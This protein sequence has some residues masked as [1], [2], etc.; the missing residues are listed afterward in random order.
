M[1]RIARKRDPRRPDVTRRGLLRGLGAGAAGA[2]ALGTGALGVHADDGDDDEDDG[3]PPLRS[4]RF[5]RMYSLPP[6][7]PPSTSVRNALIEMGRPG[8]ILD[9]KD[10]LDRGPV[11]LIIDPALS[12]TN[13]N[14]PTQTAGVTFIGQFRDHDITFDAGSRLGIPT[15]PQQSRNARTPALDLDSVYGGGPTTDPHLYDPGDRA[16]L[17][18]ESGGRFED[19]PRAADGSAIIAD[20]RNDEHLILAGLHAAF[21]LFHNRAVEEV[22]AGMA[23]AAAVFARAR[24]LTTWH[25]QWMILHEFLPQ[26]IGRP[27]VDLIL[28]GGRRYYTTRRTAFIPVEFQ[29]AAYRFGHSMVRPSY[30]ANLK[31]DND[32]P[33]FGLL[34]DPAEA[35]KPDPGD[36]RG[37]VRAPRR[38]VGWQTFFDFGD[39]D[40]RPNK[41]IDTKLSTPLFHLP[42]GAIPSRDQPTAL[43]QRNLLRH[44]TWELP[45]GQRIA[46]HMGVPVLAPRDLAELRPFHSAFDRD[47]PLWYYILKEAEVRTDGLHLGPVGGR[48]VGEVIIGLLQT[49]PAGYLSVNPGWRPTLPSRSGGGDFQMVDFL[50]FAGVHPGGRGQ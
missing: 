43:A 17:K 37:G 48:I 44:L 5:G 22:R 49:D 46:R 11:A 12:G 26:I 45:S 28:S 25:Y 23:P 19:L 6:F 24:R 8:G 15:A 1:K 33:F 10:A 21:L 14:N 20:P 39:G 3:Q 42:L 18:V 29:G 30:R 41:R 32:A 50:T 2:L 38:F 47:T 13:R 16:K 31:G 9:A 27:M 40:V 7:A 34:F 35:G 36:L 4:D